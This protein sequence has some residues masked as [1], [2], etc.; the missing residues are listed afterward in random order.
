MVEL[1][2][3]CVRNTA[4]LMR[5]QALVV[6]GACSPIIASI[7]RD[8]PS[9][10]FAVFGLAMAGLGLFALLL[11]E[12]KGSSLCDTMEAQEERVRA[13]NTSQSCLK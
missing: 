12:T 10:S 1:F 7:G 6:A 4:T 3:K 2:P 11:P 5:R 13:L 9:L 8:V